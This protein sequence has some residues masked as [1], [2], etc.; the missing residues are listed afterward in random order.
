MFST[1][2]YLLTG[3]AIDGF[4]QHLIDAISVNTERSAIYSART[5]GATDALF[6]SL[7]ASEQMIRPVARLVDVWAM[8]LVADGIPVVVNDFVPMEHN[9]PI[10]TP[11]HTAAAM[12]DADLAAANAIIA[13]LLEQSESINGFDVVDASA[14]ALYALEALEEAEGVYFAMSRHVIESLGYAALHG[15]HYS[16]DSDG[17]ADA[18]VYTLVGIQR[19]GL[20]MFDVTHYDKQANVS[21]QDGVGVLINDLPMIPFIVEYEHLESND[22]TSLQRCLQ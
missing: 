15:L 18:L 3:P 4:E 14:E 7:I 6:A 17:E 2:W 20:L 21:H 10:D 12:D 11:I 8:G 9:Q 16:C 5:D 19:L 1:L 22:R 13:T